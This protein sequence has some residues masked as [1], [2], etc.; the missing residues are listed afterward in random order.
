M[1]LTGVSISELP[2][3]TGYSENISIPVEITGTTYHLTPS[4]LQPTSVWNAL[5]TQTG[6]LTYSGGNDTPYG[7]LIFN[8]IYFI[9]EYV[10][11]DDFSNIAEVLQGT[12]NTTGCVFRATGT[13]TT[14]YIIPH[15]WDASVLSSLGEMIVT[16]LE[17]TLGFDVLV[18][19]P[20]FS[21]PQNIGIVAFAPLVDSGGF[22]TQRT[23]INAQSTIPFG[24]TPVV[25]VFMTS[26]DALTLSGVMF[27]YDP[28]SGN[29]VGDSLYN[30]PIEI[31]VF[32]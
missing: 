29:L 8:E 11:G 22:L 17:N 25:P 6:P 23:I 4:T 20:A 10:A 30:T 16:V 24:F 26:I 15:T 27:I 12:I 7:G 1:S 19:Y 18:E 14:D 13:T 32:K 3:L 31:K 2:L 9:D 28:I 5:L 21:N